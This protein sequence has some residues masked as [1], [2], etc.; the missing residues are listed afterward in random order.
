MGILIT[1]GAGFVGSALVDELLGRDP[2]ARI[3]I[4]DAL[5]YPIGD[6]NVRGHSGLRTVRG[7]V[8]D[9]A[10]L[11]TLIEEG[12]SI[13][14]LAVEMARPQL[15]VQ[16]QVAGT[17]ALLDAAVRRKAA[18][19]VYQSTCDIYGHNDSSDIDEDAPPRP[20]HLYAAT[21]LGAEALVSAYHHSYG[22]PVTILRP[23]S[24]YGPRQYPGWLIGKFCTFAIGG[25]RLPVLGD[26]AVRRDWIHVTDV[27]RA[28]AAALGAPPAGE[29]YNIGTGQEWSVIE[30]ARKVL[31]LAARSSAEVEHLEP[32][33]GDF[34]RQI[35]RARKA[36]RKLKWEPRVAF[37][38]G[39][40][41]TFDWY[42]A[43][44]PWV[45]RQLSGE[46]AQLGFRVRED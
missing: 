14:H 40:R 24:I 33:P 25:K 22:L 4:L 28:L 37:E 8:T 39:L 10:L 3:T 26:G 6:E 27:A 17:K 35:T 19:F 41:Q 20:T 38:E 45:E 31:A 13:V 16:T 36:R 7:S 34:P 15:F 46:G 18:H 9:A 44:Q 5:L 43:N 29:V 42:R 23:V 2:G 30:I 1:G 21:K 11:D 12:D 32:R